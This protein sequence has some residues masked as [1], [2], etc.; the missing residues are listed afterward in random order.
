MPF[1]PNAPPEAS[2]VR[3]ISILIV[4]DHTATREALHVLLH[5]ALAGHGLHIQTAESAESAISLVEADA[6]DIVIMDIT[7][8]GMNGIEATQI[9]RRI[10]PATDVVM[11]SNSDMDIYREMSARVGASAFVSKRHTGRELVPAILDL[12]KPAA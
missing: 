4:E 12:L 11:H 9:I 8:P 6:P 2:P 3:R 5:G 7:L 1:L 10:A